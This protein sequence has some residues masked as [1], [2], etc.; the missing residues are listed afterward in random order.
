MPNGTLKP[1]RCGA[2][3]RCAYC[4]YLVAVEN[5]L[6]VGLD[7]RRSPPT[8]GL[9]LTT[10]RPDFDMAR[11]RDAMAV[12]VRWLRR[13]YGRE[14]EYLGFVEWTTGKSGKGRMPHQHALV[15]GLAPELAEELHPVIREKWR[16]LTG[17]AWVIESRRLRTAGGAIA[18]LAHHHHKREQ[19]PPP[20]WKGKRLR[21]SQGYYSRP[22]IELRA[23]AREALT[24]SRVLRKNLGAFIEQGVP[25]DVIEEVLDGLVEEQ[26]ANPPRMVKVDDDRLR[27]VERFRA[28]RKG[29][30]GTQAS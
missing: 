28:A 23:E 11:F 3:N 24:R 17:G 15:K 21:P 9:T 29:A 16:E 14:I 4:A 5:S 8:V 12:L 6:V 27:E 1:M 22:I 18:Y 2:S 26:R 30:R 25:E 10:H 20:G 7:A 19:A 13:T